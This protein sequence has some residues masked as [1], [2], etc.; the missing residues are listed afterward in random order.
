M[1]LRQ[2]LH[3]VCVAASVQYSDIG[4]CWSGVDENAQSGGGKAGDE[5]VHDA[6]R[7]VP[8]HQSRPAPPVVRFLRL[9]AIRTIKQTKQTQQRHDI[10]QQCITKR[11]TQVAPRLG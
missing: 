6:G 2:L 1:T 10:S 9:Y 11:Q 5:P 3:G 8:Q 7:E 4:V